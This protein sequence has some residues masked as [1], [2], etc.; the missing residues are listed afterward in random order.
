[1]FHKKEVKQRKPQSNQNQRGK[2]RTRRRL[3]GFLIVFPISV[4]SLVLKILHDQNV[5]GEGHEVATTSDERPRTSAE[6]EHLKTDQPSGPD[7]VYMRTHTQTRPVWD[8][9]RT[10]Y[11][12]RWL[13]WGSMG[14]HIS[15]IWQSQTCRVWD[16]V[17]VPPYETDVRG[18]AGPQQASTLLWK[19]F[20]EHSLTSVRPIEMDPPKNHPRYLTESH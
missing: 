4:L 7:V 9:H 17:Q 2:N 14:R 12:L 8:C 10:A 19:Y 3:R 18:L 16:R 15:H 5:F 6:P 1:M 20:H 13:F 11:T